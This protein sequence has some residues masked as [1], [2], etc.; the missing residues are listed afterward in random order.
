[1]APGKRTLFKTE[2]RA[3]AHLHENGGSA[4]G[5][6][7]Y[8]ASGTSGH[9]G[10]FLDYIIG[11]GYVGKNGNDFRLTPDGRRALRKYS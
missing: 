8:R 6:D 9:P 10:H 3:M 2:V 5:L 1:M 11:M 4:P 7:V